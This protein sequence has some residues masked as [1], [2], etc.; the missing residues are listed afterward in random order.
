MNSASQKQSSAPTLTHQELKYENPWLRV[1]EHHVIHPNGEAGLF[2]VVRMKAGVSVLAIDEEDFVYLTQEFRYALQ[3]MS[4][5]VVSGGIDVGETPLQTAQRELKEELGIEAEQWTTL[6]MLNPFTTIIDSPAWL[7][8]AQ[9][10][11][12][13]ETQQE[14]HEQITMLKVPFREALQMVF[15]GSITHGGSCVAILKVAQLL[16]I[17]HL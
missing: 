1:E 15:D 10:L 9:K 14:A 3:T 8:L 5:E 7:F 2:G 16:K 17:T 12:F 4:T 11:H 13:H 6:G